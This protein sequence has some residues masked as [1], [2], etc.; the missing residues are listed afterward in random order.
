MSTRYNTGNPIEST[1]VR[2]MS[3][4]AKN[5]DLFSNSS[6]L[7]FDDRF[8]VERKTIHGMNSEFDGM[9]VGMNSEFDGMIVGMNS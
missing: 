8:G 1:D 7:S 9:I 3:D 2:D 6:E 4:N 5:L